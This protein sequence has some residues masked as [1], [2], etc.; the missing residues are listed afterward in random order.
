M[1]VFTTASEMLPRKG[2]KHLNSWEL[3]GINWKSVMVYYDR[4]ANA[5]LNTWLHS[6]Q[7]VHLTQSNF[8]NCEVL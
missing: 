2:N 5:M 8:C 3:L 1:L 6:T 4:H 7:T